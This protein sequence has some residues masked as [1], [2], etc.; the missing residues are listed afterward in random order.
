M[1]KNRTGVQRFTKQLN[2]KEILV[3]EAYQR[4]VDPKKIA[5][6]A[7]D[8]D[9]CLVNFV[10]VSFRDGKYYAFDGRHTTVL[11]KTVRGNGK[12]VNVACLVY[13]GLTRLD[14][15]ELFLQQNGDHATP[16][17]VTSKYRALYNF[18]DD[19]IHGMVDGAYA[20]GVLVDFKPNQAQNKVVALSALF[21]N[22]MKLE[23]EKYVEMLMILRQSWGGIPDSF[24]AEMLN[25]MSRFVD[26]Y[27]GRYKPR[28]L[29]RSLNN[30]VLPIQIIREG[31]SIGAAALTANT[32]ARIILRIYNNGRTT[33]RLPDEL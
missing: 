18:G 27:Y 20:A 15:M 12:D 30:K 21:R 13:T 31:K 9:P 17:N 26:V 16:P 11:E 33:H 29:I 25:A 3:D 14:E 8:Y 4:D 5:K 1:R 6:M 2:T 24:R 7:K 32:Y 10:K 23:R 19:D 22:Y 28:D